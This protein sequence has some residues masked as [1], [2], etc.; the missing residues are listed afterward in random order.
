MEWATST[1]GFAEAFLNGR[2]GAFISS[3]WSVG[4]APA[5]D[6]A[7]AFYNALK[8][9]ETASTAAT[10]GRAAARK[11]GDATWLAYAVY[12]HPAARLSITHTGDRRY[13]RSDHRNP[14]QSV[15]P[16]AL[17]RPPLLPGE[18]SRWF[19]GAPSS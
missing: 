12:A 11:A 7:I 15:V 18:P 4:D 5:A 9:G 10:A 17:R 14:R 6:F 3:L 2:A 16:K 8:F 19:R 13:G 1:G